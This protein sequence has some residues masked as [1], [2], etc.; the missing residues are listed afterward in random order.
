LQSQSAERAEGFTV[1]GKTHC[2]PQ[3]ASGHDFIRADNACKIIGLYNQRKNSLRA[4]RSVRARL[5]SRRQTPAKSLGFTGSGKAI[6]G[7]KKRQGTTLVVPQKANKSAGF[8]P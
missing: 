2:G 6:A 4:A 1:S 5:H 3:E 7:R 8:S